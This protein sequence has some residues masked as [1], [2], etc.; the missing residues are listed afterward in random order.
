MPALLDLWLPILLAAVF[1]FLVS[2][3]I[4]MATP[5]HKS[6]WKKLPGEDAILDL[7]RPRGIAPGNY[8]FPNC[9]SM[10]DFGSPEHQAKMQQGPVGWITMLAPGGVSMGRSLAQWFV[11]T[12]VVSLVVA[13][14]GSLTLAAGADTMHVFRVTGTVALLGYAFSNVMDSIWKGVKWSITLRFVVDGVVY[15]L[16]TGGTFGW[17]WPDAV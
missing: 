6:D 15:A 10:K 1:V 12:V 7:L 17:L 5:M 8:M 14:V 11:Y 4:H 13:Y 2:S 3:V 9:E 16:V